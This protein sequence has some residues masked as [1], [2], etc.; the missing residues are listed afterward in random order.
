MTLGPR[1]EAPSGT[2]TSRAVCR[3]LAKGQVFA[4][5]WSTVLQSRPPQLHALAPRLVELPWQHKVASSP[6]R[7]SLLAAETL[8]PSPPAQGGGS[9]ISLASLLVLRVQTMTSAW[10]PCRPQLAS[11]WA[12]PGF[13][14]LIPCKAAFPALLP[15]PVLC[16]HQAQTPYRICSCQTE[17]FNSYCDKCHLTQHMGC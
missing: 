6:E 16:R 10:H 1:K 5:N 3:L 11:P 15:W 13:P 8:L 14:H 17:G 9:G 2:I 12:A 7:C 4:G